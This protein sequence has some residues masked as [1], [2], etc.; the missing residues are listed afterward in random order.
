MFANIFLPQARVNRA[1]T[2]IDTGGP[3]KDITS[4]IHTAIIWIDD[5]NKQ[6]KMKKENKRKQNM[7]GIYI[8][9]WID[10]ISEFW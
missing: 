10:N 5:I 1:I 2:T 9:V 3:L 6:N 7:F 4:G 8:I